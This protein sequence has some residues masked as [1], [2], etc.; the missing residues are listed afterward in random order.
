[1]IF[2]RPAERVADM[3]EYLKAQKSE[4][5]DAIGKLAHAEDRLAYDQS[6]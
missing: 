2:D 6:R 1:M 5:I 3:A 4:V